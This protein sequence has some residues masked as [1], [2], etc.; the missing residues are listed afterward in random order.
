MELKKRMFN[1]AP[2]HI[3]MIKDLKKWSYLKSGAVV[4]RRAIE[5]AWREEA[6]KRGEFDEKEFENT[7]MEKES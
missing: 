2:Y 5:M 3:Q 7:I 6:I 1:L 4:V